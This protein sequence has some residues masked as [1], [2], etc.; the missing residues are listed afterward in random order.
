MLSCLQ[1]PALWI[2]WI[3]PKLV[4]A[5]H[6]PDPCPECNSELKTCLVLSPCLLFCSC[7]GNWNLGKKRILHIVSNIISKIVLLLWYVILYGM[8]QGSN[9]TYVV[10]MVCVVNSNCDDVLISMAI[11]LLAIASCMNLL[12]LQRLNFWLCSELLFG[13][14][15]SP[16]LFSVCKVDDGIVLP[17][18]ASLYLTAIED[19]EYKDDKIECKTYMTLALMSMDKIADM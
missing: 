17:D 16:I 14:L 18:K 12:F 13:N 7:K 5:Y 9:C 10:L 8:A 11:L 19:A 3:G 1:Y 2:H 4:I 15:K 6:K